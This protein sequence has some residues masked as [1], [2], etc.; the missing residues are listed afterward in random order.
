MSDAAETSRR[1]RRWMRTETRSFPYGPLHPTTVPLAREL[2]FLF[3][4]Q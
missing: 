1:E 4:P 3:I 2:P